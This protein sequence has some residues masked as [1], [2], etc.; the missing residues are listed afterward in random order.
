MIY[1]YG[2]MMHVFINRKE[3]LNLPTCML[4]NKLILQH[5]Q[6]FK[7]ILHNT[8]HPPHTTLCPS[9]VC[10]LC[11]HTTLPP[12]TTL[13]PC[14]VC[15]HNIIYTPGSEQWNVTARNSGKLQTFWGTIIE[16]LTQRGVDNEVFKPT[17][18]ILCKPPS[19]VLLRN[20]SKGHSSESSIPLPSRGFLP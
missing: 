10:N 3:G 11:V 9:L 16:F 7:L 6:H 2:N 14:L 13:C 8:K 12:R 5:S 18:K 15:A 17:A 1:T 4:L 20:F 19:H